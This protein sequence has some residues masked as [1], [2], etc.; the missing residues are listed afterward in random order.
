MLTNTNKNE[1]TNINNS[2]QNSKEIKED[3]ENSNHNI[4]DMENEITAM[5]DKVLDEKDIEIATKSVTTDL[6]SLQ[7]IEEEDN[8]DEEYSVQTPRN[9]GKH[10]TS[11]PL[12]KEKSRF[13]MFHEQGINRVSKRYQTVNCN[14]TMSNTELNESKF[15]NNNNNNVFLYQNYPQNNL[16][17]FRKNVDI[18]NQIN[19]NN[20]SLNQ[21]Q[22]IQFSQMI[23][24]ANCNFIR[25]NFPSK[26][27]VYHFNQNKDYFNINNNHN[28]AIY[29]YNINN[30]NMNQNMKNLNYNLKRGDKRKNTYDIPLCFAVNRKNY[31]I[32]NNIN[33]PEFNNQFFG[34]NNMSNQPNNII[35]NNNNNYN[36]NYNNIINQLNPGNNN[37]IT[38][39]DDSK[40]QKLKTMLEKSG[41]IDHYIY[42]II[43]GKILSIL[44][45]HKGSRIFQKYLKSTHCDIL[46]Q[47][48][49]ELSYN[50]DELFT[51]PYANYFCKK[52][53]TYL[54]QK[55]RAELLKSIEKSIVK[56]SCDSV[57]TFTIQTIIEHVGSKS[58]KIIIASAIKENVKE[59][60]FDPFGTYVLERLLTY[61]EEEYI[62]F[63][64]SYII[65]HFTELACDNNGIV[66]VKKIIMF[67][68]KKVLHD[69]IK[70]IIKEN[71]MSL[72]K[73]PYASV[74]LQVIIESWPDYKDMIE[75]YEDKY[76][77]FS[78]DKYASNVVERCLE[79]DQN[80]LNK[81]IDDII[82]SEKIHE[83]MKSNYGNYV[84]QKAIKLATGEY[85][86]KI[87]ENA[88]KNV[89]KLNDPKL[90]IKWKSILMPY[91]KEIGKDNIKVFVE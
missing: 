81:Y 34:F 87:V 28:S 91:I 12:N 89:N 35:M 67:T 17:N 2:L 3:S 84:I 11:I 40:I 41:K 24:N 85:K 64:Y 23:N 31:N 78:T 7:F 55:D 25:N 16:G 44:K 13:K 66:V 19:L 43:K 8:E 39:T 75:L 15:L 22:Q 1:D 58:E 59:L 63:I 20:F 33:N 72:I 37:N 54:S 9:S 77:V 38:I 50:L 45:N 46:H 60:S 18:N 76:F 42:N 82:N 71:V 36:N 68:H 74:L 30:V 61:F 4:F 48:F 10:Q 65:D 69:K 56:Y 51:D 52:F 79:K 73:H 57:G 83:V 27:V 49:I 70:N 14:Q 80:I 21:N 6:D 86:E 53:F 88:A 32:Q 47:I 62:S 26:T 5:L 90:I 29:G